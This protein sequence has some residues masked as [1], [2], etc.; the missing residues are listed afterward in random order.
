MKKSELVEAV[1]RKMKIVHDRAVSKADVEALINSLTD[2]VTE[3]LVE[4][5]EVALPRLGRF[6]TIE[7]STRQGRNPRTGEAMTISASIT[8][9]FTPATTLKQ[10]LNK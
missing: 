5:S 10:A 7:R 8:A 1:T 4:G 9:K 2:C 6:S 3:E